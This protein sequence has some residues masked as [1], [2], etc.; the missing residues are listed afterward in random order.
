VDGQPLPR[1]DEKTGGDHQ[2]EVAAG[3]L[4]DSRH[5][6]QGVAS[7]GFPAYSVLVS[8][9][10]R[11]VASRPDPGG[12]RPTAEH[13][14]DGSLRIPRQWSDSTYGCGRAAAHRCPLSSRGT[15]SDRPAR[16]RNSRG[17][18]TKVTAAGSHDVPQAA[19]R[20]QRA[21]LRAPEW[22]PPGWQRRS[23]RGRA[24]GHMKICLK[25]VREVPILL[26][27]YGVCR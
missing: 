19:A 3:T 6:D 4:P 16:L 1:D 18:V 17:V 2:Q 15:N 10:R 20:S 23:M 14:G 27:R 22:L 7:L 21:M 13:A 11:P 9:A 12:R 24:A 8:Q 25:V 26:R 5:M